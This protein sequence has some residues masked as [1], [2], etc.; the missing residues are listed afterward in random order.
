L[1]S[2]QTPI[3]RGRAYWALRGFVSDFSVGIFGTAVSFLVV[4]VYLRYLSKSEYGYWLTIY[5]TLSF[6]GLLE[7]GMGTY[8][9]R[10]VADP[11]LAYD[12]ERLSATVSTVMA[13]FLGMAAIALLLGI[14]GAPLLPRWF[15]VSSTLGKQAGMVVIIA[16]MTLALSFPASI[17]R[18]LLYAT[19]QMWAGN[20]LAGVANFGTN[21]LPIVLMACGLGLMSL[22]ISELLMGGG[23]LGA[24]YFATRHLVP[25]FRIGIALFNKRD[26]RQLLTYSGPFQLAKIANAISVSA[27]NAIIS[28]FLGTGAVPAYVITAKLHSLFCLT[29]IPKVAGS[30]FPGMSEMYAQGRSDRLRVLFMK[31]SRYLTRI[32]LVCM[33]FVYAMNKTFVSLWVGPELY[34]GAALTAVFLVWI[35]RDTLCRSIGV[36]LYASGDLNGLGVVSVL[37]AILNVLLSVILVR[38]W[39]VLGVALGTAI[40]NS[41]TT[42]LYIPFKICRGLAI[43]VQTYIVYSLLF[44]IAKSLPGVVVT[45]GVARVMQS[46]SALPAL[47]VVGMCAVL[48]NV[49]IF[50]I[51]ELIKLS[52]MPWD[53]RLRQLVSLEY[54]Y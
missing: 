4:P 1:A 42:G 20:L 12:E 22:P 8:V 43:P 19:Q 17:F 34:G 28:S 52:R 44:P 3:Q 21:V 10:T 5:Q 25:K 45:I 51:P 49:A 14:A 50:E 41:F 32:A 7:F 33:V 54:D 6:L 36:F 46:Y 40:A 39:G 48:A 16:S 9:V 38:R 11:A 2:I 47:V 53:M 24:A 31:F 27:D 37:E 29:L 30:M 13:V 18:S 35:F 15:G 23:I 26:F